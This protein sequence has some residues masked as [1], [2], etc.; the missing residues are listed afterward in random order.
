MINLNNVTVCSMH[1]SNAD[2]RIVD[3]QK[4]VFGAFGIIVRQYDKTDTPHGVWMNEIMTHAKRDEVILFCDIDAIPLNEAVVAS[5]I[6]T[7]RSGGIFGCAQAAN[8]LA[9]SNYI[10]AG[11]MFLA[12]SKQT[13]ISAGCPNFDAHISQE[14]AMGLSRSAESRNISIQLLYPNVVCVPKWRLG[15]KGV[16]GIGTFY[17]CNVFHLFEARSGSIYVDVFSYVANT[18]LTRGKIDYLHA[19]E[20]AERATQLLR[21]RGWRDGVLHVLKKGK[22]FANKG[23]ITVQTRVADG[24]RLSRRSK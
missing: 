21:R 17:E 6:A 14:V 4:R 13:W 3:L 20:L 10:Y 11:P 8:H 19:I 23:K 24:L 1:W 2:R 22:R 5:A 7:A 16:F 9:D 18:V 12:L 15:E